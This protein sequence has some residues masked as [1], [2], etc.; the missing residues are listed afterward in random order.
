MDTQRCLLIFKRNIFSSFLLFLA[1]DILCK[2]Q[3][4][5]ATI[6]FPGG[7]KPTIS[8]GVFN[9]AMLY[10]AS[11]LCI[12]ILNFDMLEDFCCCEMKGFSANWNQLGYLTITSSIFSGLR[13]DY[14]WNLSWSVST[15]PLFSSGPFRMNRKKSIVSR[16]VRVTKNESGERNG[17][18]KVSTLVK[19]MCSMFFT[20]TK[21]GLAFFMSKA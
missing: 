7:R 17:N 14:P 12:F 9:V 13:G 19:E 6:C 18:L 16:K 8:E 11:L 2:S 10:N 20:E 3:A 4:W 1:S 21:G 15:A 5:W